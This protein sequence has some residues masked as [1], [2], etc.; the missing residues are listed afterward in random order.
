MRFAN[1]STITFG[2]AC[3]DDEQ[4]QSNEF[5]YLWWPMTNEHAARRFAQ[6][7]DLQRAIE[8]KEQEVRDAKSHARELEEQAKGLHQ[9]L[10]AAA[11]DEGDLPLLDMMEAASD[12]AN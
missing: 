1:G 6:V 5:Q 4:W 11:R 2:P 8:L 9:E 12:K 7:A 10:R 3:D